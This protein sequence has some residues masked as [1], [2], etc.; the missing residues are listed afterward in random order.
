MNKWIVVNYLNNNSIE[1]ISDIW[2][3]QNICAW[4]IN[5]KMFKDLQ[6]QQTRLKLNKKE[7]M[8]LSAR[9]LGNQVYGNYI[10]LF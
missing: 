3:K 10:Y 1:S 6:K 8:F 9:K 4:S 2:L 5:K 7:F